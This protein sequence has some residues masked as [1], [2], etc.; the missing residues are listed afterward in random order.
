M[1][2][3]PG[4]PVC[5]VI[6][7]GRMKEREASFWIRGSPDGRGIGEQLNH[8]GQPEHTLNSL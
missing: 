3:F 7:N 8:H 6:T 5:R 4:S 2:N 1:C